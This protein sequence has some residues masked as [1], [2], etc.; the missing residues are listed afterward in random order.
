MTNIPTS[1]SLRD[2]RVCDNCLE[3]IKRNPE[4]AT[5]WLHARN[6]MKKCPDG[7]TN[8]ARPARISLPDDII[9]VQLGDRVWYRNKHHRRNWDTELWGDTWTDRRQGVGYKTIDELLEQGDVFVV[10]RLEKL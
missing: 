6:G 5:S 1:G 2:T 3:V 4:K 9:T 8:I 7:S 10:R